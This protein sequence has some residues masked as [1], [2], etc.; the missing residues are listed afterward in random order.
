MVMLTLDVTL[1]WQPSKIEIDS[2]N[3]TLHVSHWKT[4]HGGVFREGN[5]L[6]QRNYCKNRIFN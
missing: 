5:V 1:S 6:S 4:K 3:T 2:L